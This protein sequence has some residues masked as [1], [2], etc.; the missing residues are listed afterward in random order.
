MLR[1]LIVDDEPLARAR[2]RTLLAADPELAI[3]GECG[4]GPDAVAT[5][6][7]VAP[8]LVLLDLQMPGFDGLEVVRRVGV[9]QMPPVVFITA[10]TDYT[11]EAFASIAVDYILKPV[12]WQRLGD[13]V[14]RAKLRATQYRPRL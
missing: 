12:D 1:V 8:D 3:V 10:H 9:D 13:A 2:L 5:I 6:G 4:N 11:V 7:R 14:Q